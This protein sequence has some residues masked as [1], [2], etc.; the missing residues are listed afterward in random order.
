MSISSQTMTLHRNGRADTRVS[1]PF[2]RILSVAEA[3]RAYQ[4]IRQWTGYKRTPLLELAAAAER[5]GVRRVFYKDEAPRFGLGSFKALGGA[6]A[7][8]RLL[9]DLTSER[10]DTDLTRGITVAC[11]SDGNHGRSVAAG[12]KRKLPVQGAPG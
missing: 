10:L 2:A 3:Q 6:Y 8:A 1:Y 4:E 7:V 11:A 9:Q 5:I 12:A